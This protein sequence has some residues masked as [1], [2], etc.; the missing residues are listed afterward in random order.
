MTEKP[1][2]VLEKNKN[3]DIYNSMTTGQTPSTEEDHVRHS[4]APEEQLNG[5]YGEIVF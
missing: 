4:N 3:L 2:K 1:L 5:P